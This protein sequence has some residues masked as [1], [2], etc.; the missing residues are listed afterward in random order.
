MLTEMEMKLMRLALDPSAQVGEVQNAAVMFFNSLRKRGITYDFLNGAAK[1]SKPPQKYKTRIMPFGKHKGME[2]DDIEPNYLRWVY[3]K[4]HPQLD[5]EGQ[6]DWMHLMR[7]IE[8]YFE[9][10]GDHL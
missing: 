9:L 7:D 8:D 4:W 1:Q 2:F 3:N 5:N 6:K 10:I